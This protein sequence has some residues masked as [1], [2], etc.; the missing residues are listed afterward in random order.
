MRAIG[1]LA[2]LKANVS[3]QTGLCSGICP[4]GSTLT[5]PDETIFFIDFTCAQFDQVAK[6]S[7]NITECEQ[8]QLNAPICGCTGFTPVCPGI[9]STGETISFPEKIIP[10]FGNASCEFL[11][12]LT[13]ITF[14]NQTACAAVQDA[15]SDFCGCSANGAITPAPSG[16]LALP[17]S[18]SIAPAPS[19]F[20]TPFPN[21]AAITPA[22]SG[23]PTLSPSVTPVAPTS[24]VT[25]PTSTNSTTTQV[26]LTTSPPVTLSPLSVS[27][28]PGSVTVPTP[29]SIKPSPKTSSSVYLTPWLAMSLLSASTFTFIM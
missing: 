2:L 5:L 14:D 6:E 3:A 23:F 4:E 11:D 16:V 22:P 9:C 19:G 29:I 13:K 17:T 27:S 18:V 24:T 15:F 25:E 10:D 1:I 28:S 20:L 8:L 12:D 21:S 7:N 26:P